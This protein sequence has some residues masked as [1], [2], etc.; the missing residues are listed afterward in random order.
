MAAEHAYFFLEDY[1]KIKIRKKK[2]AHVAT[3]FLATLLAR[4]SV[5]VAAVRPFG[6]LAWIMTV[7]LT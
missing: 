5:F 6:Q 1:L 4:P 7:G 3:Q 2:T